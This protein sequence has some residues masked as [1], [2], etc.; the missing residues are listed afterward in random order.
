MKALGIFVLFVCVIGIAIF[1]I[2]L[3]MYNGVIKANNAVDTAWG[4]VQNQYQRRADMIPNLVEVVKGAAAFEKETFIA[5]AEAR[6]NASK[7]TV[8][9]S[10]VPDQATLE[11]YAEAQQ[12]LGTA[13]SRLMMVQEKYPDLKANQNFL[14]LQTQLESTENRI[15]TERGRF[16]QVVLALNNKVTTF[17]GSFFASMAGIQKRPN[18]QATESSQAV[19]VVKF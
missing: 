8:D 10:K 14:G 2:G 7:I 17:P 12:G 11:K 13:I 9:P 15:S 18:F 6:A 5:V 4:Q 3:S 1:G 16:N 19:P